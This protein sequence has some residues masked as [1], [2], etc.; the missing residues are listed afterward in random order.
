MRKS[1]ISDHKT[2]NFFISARSDCLEKII[3]LIAKS[4][5][6]YK[7]IFLSQKWLVEKKILEWGQSRMIESRKN[8]RVELGVTY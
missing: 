8:S 1:V 7:N 2:C 5:C 6:Y 4:D 3:W